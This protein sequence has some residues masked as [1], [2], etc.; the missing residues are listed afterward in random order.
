MTVDDIANYCEVKDCQVT[1]GDAETGF[2]RVDGTGVTGPYNNYRR[3]LAH[4]E[5]SALPNPDKVLAATTTF[6]VEANCNRQSLS[7]EDFEVDLKRFQELAG[8]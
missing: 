6:V 5:L 2:V 8:A 7:R 3:F 1:F 4:H